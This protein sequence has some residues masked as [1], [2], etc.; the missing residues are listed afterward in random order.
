[1]VTV[2]VVIATAIS[3]THCICRRKP[4]E[5]ATQDNFQNAGFASDTA[6]SIEIY[7]IPD[8]EEDYE[9]PAQYA[10]LDS[11]KRVPIDGNY[12]SLNADYTRLDRGL[13][14]NVPQYASLNMACN[15]RNDTPAEPEYETVT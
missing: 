9:E 1:M 11:S 4:R 3:V 5:E 6:E 14:E 10:Q 8:T 13:I 12:Q 7:Q 2:V 15:S